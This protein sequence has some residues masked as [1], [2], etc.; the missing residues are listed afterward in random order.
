MRTVNQ[1]F[2][3]TGK[4]TPEFISVWNTNIGGGETP[5]NSLRLP[6]E[7]GTLATQYNF[8]VD[9]GDGTSNVITSATDPALVHVYATGGIYTLRIRGIIQGFKPNASLDRVKLLEIQNWGPCTISVS[10]MF[11]QCTNMNITA[12]DIPLITTNNIQGMFRLCPNFVFNSSINN[13]DV[14]GVTSPSGG[15]SNNSNGMFRDANLFNQ[16]LNNWNTSNFTNLSNMFTNTQFNQPLNNWNVGNVTDFN[17]CFSF[18]PFNQ[19]INSWNVASGLRFNNMFDGA[20]QFN[21]PLN[22]WNM[23]NALNVSGMFRSATNFNQPL[24][25]WNTVNIQFF[26]DANNTNG[27]GMLRAAT[28]FNQDLTSWSFANATQMGSFMLNKT[29][30]NYTVTNLDPIYQRMAL[31]ATRTGVFLNMGTLRYTTAGQ[32]HRNHLTSV[33]GWTIIDGGLI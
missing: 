22:N 21:Q 1:Y 8:T 23:S 33:L 17:G 6:L 4:S 9:W 12:T 29:P 25:N 13:W 18:S 10:D 14:S 5:S 2:I 11:R 3:S 20:T 24:N 19:N 26:G 15:T 27:N 16:P 32:V 28:A 7:P 30:L 31:T